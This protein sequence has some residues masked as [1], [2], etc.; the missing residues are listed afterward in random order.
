MNWLIKLLINAALVLL[1]AYL[2]PGVGVVDY[3]AALIVAAVLA[4]LN[5]LVKPLLIIITIPITI[6]T[7]G[8]FLLV[9]NALIIMLADHLIDGFQVNSFWWALL[10]S[11]IM[12]FFNS[13]MKGKSRKIKK[14]Q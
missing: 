10:F 1:T 9:I 8:L 12:S 14:I 13:F 2:L 5:I 3:T 11:F 7:F 4:V 6:L